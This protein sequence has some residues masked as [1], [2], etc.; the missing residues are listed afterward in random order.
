MVGGGIYKAKDC[1]RKNEN[2]FSKWIN[3]SHL[4]V[5]KIDPKTSVISTEDGD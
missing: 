5:V 1:V 2:L 3:F 4:K